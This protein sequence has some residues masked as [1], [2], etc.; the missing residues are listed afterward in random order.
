MPTIWKRDNKVYATTAKYLVFNYFTCSYIKVNLYMGQFYEIHH[1]FW[2][3][4]ISN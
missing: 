4:Q 2:D 1:A 3:Q